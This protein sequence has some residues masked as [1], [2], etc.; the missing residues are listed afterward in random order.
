MKQ[1]QPLSPTL[2]HFYT[3]K[4]NFWE[5]ATLLQQLISVYRPKNQRF[6]LKEESSAWKN[7]GKLW[8]KLRWFAV[9]AVKI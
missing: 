4:L 6:P 3:K 9:S 5:F 8:L 1:L 2:F 7:S